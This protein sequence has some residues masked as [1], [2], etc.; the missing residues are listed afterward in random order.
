MR[1]TLINKEIIKRVALALG[2]LNNVVIYVGGATVSLY[3]NDPAA[4]DVRPTKDIDI[5]LQILSIPQLEEIREQLNEKGFS[6]SAD[7]DVICRFKL[8]DILVDVMSTKAVGWAPANPW[9]AK[10]F[11]KREK[12]KIDD[13]SIQI[14]PLPYFL[15][16]KFS[17]FKDRGGND[18]RQSKDLEDITY[19]LN[20]RTDWHEVIKDSGKEV[21]DFLKMHFQE[22]SKS[23]G[24]QEAMRGFL[25]YEEQSERF[26]MITK[27][28]DYLL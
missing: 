7:L 24:I 27:K 8:D 16:S 28:I 12:V 22:I 18:P 25:F 14:M 17:A 5:S 3:I 13:I 11:D 2:D 21:I 4:D 26:K 20:N 23:A 15:A 1:N 6:Q 9:F 10:G 19:I